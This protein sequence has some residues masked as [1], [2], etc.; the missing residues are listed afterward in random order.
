MQ[1]WAKWKERAKVGMCLGRSPQHNRNVA[2]VLDRKTGPLFFTIE[3]LYNVPGM[4]DVRGIDLQKRLHDTDF[5]SRYEGLDV[6]LIG[7]GD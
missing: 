4:P 7:G 2:L 5:L 3:E 1:E 6:A